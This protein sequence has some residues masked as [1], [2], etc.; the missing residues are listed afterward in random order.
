M[1]LPIDNYKPKP[2]KPIP[3]EKSEI[4]SQKAS[5]KQAN[6]YEENESMANNSQ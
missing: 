1:P 6:E 4:R 2:I 3:Y 5:N